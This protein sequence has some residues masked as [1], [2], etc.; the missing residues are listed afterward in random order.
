MMGTMSGACGRLM[1]GRLTAVLLA[2]MMSAVN[3]YGIDDVDRLYVVDGLGETL[4]LV[5]RAGDSVA[6]NVMTLG[7]VPNRVRRHGANLLV[8]NSVSDDLWVI[9][10]ADFSVVRTVDF[11]AGDNPWDVCVVNDTLCAV[12]MVLSNSVLFL[13]PNSGD[14][15]WRV[16]VGLS[17]QGMLAHGRRVWVANTGF[18]YGTF[19]YDSGTVSVVDWTLQSVSNT[20]A[21]GSNPQSVAMASDGTIH[22]ACT[23]NFFDRF[24]VVYVLDTVTETVLDSM[25]TGGFPSELVIG[26]D[27][28]GYLAA[29]GFV[30]GGEIYV[31][32][33]VTRAVIHGSANPQLSA[34]GVL[35]VVPRLEGGVTAL[36]FG[37]DVLLEHDQSG[38]AVDS[39]NVGDGPVAAVHVTNRI[40]GDIVADSII[41]VFDVVAAVE[42]AFR[43]GDL[44]ERPGVAD[45]NADCVVNVFDV[46]AMVD[47]AF[48]NGSGLLWGCA[49]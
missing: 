7:T 32:D 23:G 24:G 40:P 21:V 45:V 12:S 30:A 5:D 33:A 43:A 37:A 18:D 38:T 15:L 42:I 36:C 49:Q 1:V 14:T 47:V 17:P 39:W 13:N 31:Y 22:T 29:G 20:I 9:D 48:R 34:I 28:R 3:T 10:P 26:P 46:V 4:T 19:E 6:V 41:N 8:V 27:K 16:A 25:P 11:P 2:A 35:Y 44:P